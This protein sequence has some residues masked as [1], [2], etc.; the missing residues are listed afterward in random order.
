MQSDH[1]LSPHSLPI[2]HG[3]NP[4]RSPSLFAVPLPE[5]AVSSS[6]F[7]ASSSRGRPELDAGP[8]GEGS[9]RTSPRKDGAGK[10]GQGYGLESLGRDEAEVAKRRY[11]LMDD[12]QIREVL[13]QWERLELGEGGRSDKGVPA[14]QT[15]G[16][17]SAVPIPKPIATASGESANR[18]EILANV[19]GSSPPSPLFPPSPPS[20]DIGHSHPQAD[21]TGRIDHPLRVLARAVLELQDTV[22]RLRKENEALRGEI[23]MGGRTIRGRNGASRGAAERV[24]FSITAFGGRKQA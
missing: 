9:S 15:N 17:S 13:I 12:E 6:Y 2:L 24:I 22:E 18:A 5:E 16:T 3:S 1:P 11:D 21:G 10:E 19:E 4:R 8:L 14:D 23:A 20:R 7:G